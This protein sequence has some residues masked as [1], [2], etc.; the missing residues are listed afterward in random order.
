MSLVNAGVS[1]S[2]EFTAYPWAH[3]LDILRYDCHAFRLVFD[4]QAAE[5]IASS[6]GHKPHHA[7]HAIGWL[8]EHSVNI[9]LLV[10]I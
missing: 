1:G 7:G 5:I 4:L 8:D 6:Q 10:G 3:E 9:V 2:F